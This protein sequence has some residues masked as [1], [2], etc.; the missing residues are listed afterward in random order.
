[1]AENEIGVNNQ[2]NLEEHKEK[3]GEEILALLGE[4]TQNPGEAFVLLQ[5][6]SIYIWAQYKVDWDNHEGHQVADT[7][8]QRLLDFIS[9]LIDQVPEDEALSAE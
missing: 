5:Q 6:L 4:R 8:K 1:V 3:L 7:R 2:G 9:G